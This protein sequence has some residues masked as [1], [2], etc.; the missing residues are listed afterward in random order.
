[1]ESAE[2]TVTGGY[3]ACKKLLKYRELTAIFCGNDAMA[4]GCYQAIYEAGK[5]VPEDISVIGFDALKLTEYI[6]PPLTT[7]MQPTFEIGFTAAKFLVDAIEFPSRRIPNKIFDT[8]LILRESVK[9]LT[10]AK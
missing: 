6:T 3:D 4:I 7:V 9:A 5:K 1:M 8:K 2:L 10:I